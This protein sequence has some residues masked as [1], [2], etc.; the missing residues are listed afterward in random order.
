LGKALFREATWEEDVQEAS[1]IVL[2]AP[3]RAERIA[4]R[5]RDFEGK[6][7]KGVPYWPTYSDEST[8]RETRPKSGAKTELEK[9]LDGWGDLFF[10]GFAPKRLAG[11]GGRIMAWRLMDLHV[12]REH[13]EKTGHVPGYSRSNGDG[14]SDFRVF[15]PADL[16]T[17]FVI[18]SNEQQ[19]WAA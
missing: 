4:A 10:Y 18:A 8:L 12:F 15:K 17:E 5:L 6:T 13:V 14:S 9:I 11:E 3:E 16:P 2:S 19:R 7:P 1:D